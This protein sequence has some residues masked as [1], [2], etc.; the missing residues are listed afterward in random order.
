MRSDH[1]YSEEK[2]STLLRLHNHIQGGDHFGCCMVINELI[3]GWV[4]G[5]TDVKISAAATFPTVAVVHRIPRDGSHANSGVSAIGSVL[6]PTQWLVE[7]E[8]MARMVE[9]GVSERR[10]PV[11]FEPLW[12]ARME[13]EL[14][15]EIVDEVL[16]KSLIPAPP[17]W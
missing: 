3:S 15:S 2:R 11:L 14:L 12:E 1:P 7:V 16:I 9:L 13:G 17:K 5:W 6:A 4:D 10:I 8:W